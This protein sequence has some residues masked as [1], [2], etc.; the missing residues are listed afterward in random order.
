MNT[1]FSAS[2]VYCILFTAAPLI[3]PLPSNGTNDATTTDLCT[4]RPR[5]PYI[6][7]GSSGNTPTC[8][9]TV[10][11][12]NVYVYPGYCNYICRS[13]CDCGQDGVCVNVSSKEC[14]TPPYYACAVIMNGQNC[15]K[16]LRPANGINTTE[17][18]GGTPFGGCFFGQDEVLL[19][20]GHHRKIEDLNVGDR[21]YTMN[22]YNNKIQE[23][24][25][26]MMMHVD[27]RITDDIGASG[28]EI[29][30]SSSEEED[31]E[32]LLDNCWDDEID[33]QGHY[34]EDNLSNEDDDEY[35]LSRDLSQTQRASF[36]GIRIQFFFTENNRGPLFYLFLALFYTIETIT[37]HR[38]TVTP[39]HYIRISNGKY[40]SAEQ[41]TL[42]HFVYIRS[43]SSLYPVQIKSIIKSYKKGLYAPVT[44]SGTL[45]VN[46]IVASCY[47]NVF[48]GTHDMMHMALFP[49]RLWYRLWKRGSYS[50]HDN[51]ENGNAYHWIIKIM[52]DFHEIVRFIWSLSVALTIYFGMEFL[53]QVSYLVQAF[54]SK[55]VL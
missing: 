27:K 26:I 8:Y 49:I 16:T 24:E 19:L 9:T 17:G 18:A 38:I 21:I 50:H 15:N 35:V 33:D 4:V 2:N 51:V 46:G 6:S 53:V 37:G 42:N 39:D 45:L 32:D 31:E 5:S 47:V 25:I 48:D 3:C 23:D 40:S 34:S 52:I 43:E 41:L 22:S 10:D 7:N 20:N 36:S 44:L 13:N 28:S 55:K 11:N 1:T 12:Q 14:G 29:E 54:T 30:N